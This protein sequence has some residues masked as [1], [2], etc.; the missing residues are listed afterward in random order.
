MQ[1]VDAREPL[2]IL[3]GDVGVGSRSSRCVR[4]LSRVRFGISD[5]FSHGL[6]WHMLADR[7]SRSDADGEKDWRQIFERVERQFSRV[8]RHHK[9][10]AAG[11]E[12]R[13]AVR[14]GVDHGASAD[15]G[16]AACAIFHDDRL[17]PLLR[18]PVGHGARNTVVRTSRSERH[19]EFHALSGEILSGRGRGETKC[20]NRYC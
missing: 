13:M 10:S 20:A 16:C 18:Q 2:E 8:R 3:G 4:E 1:H 6:G 12:Q 9:R 15:H 5:Q 7:H 19:D 11:E 14:S 17:A